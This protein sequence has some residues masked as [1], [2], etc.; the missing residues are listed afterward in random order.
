MRLTEKVN[1]KHCSYDIKKGCLCSAFKKLGQLEDIEEELGIDLITF[2]KYL[3]TDK[4]Y[5][6]RYRNN[7]E[8]RIFWSINTDSVEVVEEKYPYG[9]CT[10]KLMFKDYGKTWTLTKE[11]L[12]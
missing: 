8:E 5:V 9:D 3:F 7:I 2:F 12:L 1:D 10:E 4:F 11:E 6:R